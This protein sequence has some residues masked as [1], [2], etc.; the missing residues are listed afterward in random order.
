VT[1]QPDTP[2][3]LEAE[4]R[5]LAALLNSELARPL[6][7]LLSQINVYE[8]T[9]TDP[10]TVM[11]TS[12]I[13]ALARQVAQRLAMLSADLYPEVL[14]SAGLAAAIERHLYGVSQT[15]TLSA[16]V[17]VTGTPE[18]LPASIELAVFRAVQDALSAAIR[19]NVRHVAIELEYSTDRFTCHLRGFPPTDPALQSALAASLE[20]ISDLGGTLES[21]PLSITFLARPTLTQREQEILRL[22]SEGL[23]NKQI[24]AR[25]HIT[26]RTVNFHLDNLFSKLG[27]SN[28]TEAVVIGLNLLK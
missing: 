7:L 12:V 19:Q 28:R 3:S 14:E 6:N 26:P 2:N 20:R 11:V 10:Q 5:R 4:R 27:V 17:Q 25:L 13:G 15:S 18:R 16:R 21:D 9:I 22:L 24:A 1:D 8:Q 23:S